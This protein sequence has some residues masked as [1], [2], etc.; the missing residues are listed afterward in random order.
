MLKSFSLL[1]FCA[2][3]F[4]TTSAQK[5][6]EKILLMTGKFID[7]KV[8]SE[9]SAYVHYSFEKKSGKVKE[10]KLDLE[11][12]FSITDS[13][14]EEKVYYAVDTF[15]GNYFSVEEMRSY[16]EGE[17]DA[18]NYNSGNWTYAVGVPLTAGAGYLLSSTI[19]A[20]PL[21]FIYT[22]V[23]TIPKHKMRTHKS[24]HSSKKDDPAYILGYERTARTKRLFKSLFAGLVGTAS[25]FAIGVLTQ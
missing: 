20:F 2:L 12:I 22:I 11:R 13:S 21:P 3:I 5:A 1:M 7:G 4:S 24:I 19:L 9:D 14:G 18:S 10:S 17:V 16:I 6:S 8:L 23:S 15:M 25:G